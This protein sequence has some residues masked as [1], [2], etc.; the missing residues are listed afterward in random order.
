MDANTGGQDSVLG[1]PGTAALKLIAEG[2]AAALDRLEAAGVI[3]VYDAGNLPTTADEHRLFPI[4]GPSGIDKSI[5]TAARRRHR[6]QTG[7]EVAA[8]LA[9][10][11]L[12]RLDGTLTA[13]S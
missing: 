9:A 10:S 3:L 4:D 12:S 1:P 2:L 8:T 13:P 11:V 6:P 5:V 7:E